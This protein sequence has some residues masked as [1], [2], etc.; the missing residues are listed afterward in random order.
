MVRFAWGRVQGAAVFSAGAGACSLN[1]GRVERQARAIAFRAAR[2][3]CSG[4]LA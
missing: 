4:T 3:G 1:A 2:D